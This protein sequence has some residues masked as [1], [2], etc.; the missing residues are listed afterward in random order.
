[1][2]P[3]LR[4]GLLQFGYQG[5]PRVSFLKVGLRY[6]PFRSVSARQVSMVNP[7]G[8][9]PLGRFTRQTSWV[10]SVNITV[11]LNDF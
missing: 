7:S 8:A 1:M 11:L 2:T 6:T 5:N 3:P 9:F 10:S 4:L